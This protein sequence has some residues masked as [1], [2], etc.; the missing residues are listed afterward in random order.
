MAKTRV[1]PPS[2]IAPSSI[3]GDN[4]HLYSR[5]I[6]LPFKKIKLMHENEDCQIIIYTGEV[7]DNSSAEIVKTTKNLC[8]K[9]KYTSTSKT[10][11]ISGT[12][13]HVKTK[14][15]V[16]E[17]SVKKV[18]LS[19]RHNAQELKLNDFTYAELIK[20]ESNIINSQDY[21]SLAKK[22]ID[23]D[24]NSDGLIELS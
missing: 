14:V 24:F 9:T 10:S 17:N 8:L 18:K 5:H 3:I 7:K 6:Y 11:K 20:E 19:G 1:Y 2:K 15:K 13:I 4:I 12:H 16:R 21:A 22:K 23:L